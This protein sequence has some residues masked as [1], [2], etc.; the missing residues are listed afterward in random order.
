ML[1]NGS[2]S[3]SH[4]TNLS[5]GFLRVLGDSCENQVKHRYFLMNINLLL[6]SYAYTIYFSRVV[7]KLIYQD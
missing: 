1:I 7:Q 5:G 3:A 6:E 4:R 2:K